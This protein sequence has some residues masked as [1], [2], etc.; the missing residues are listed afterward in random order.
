ML[1]L[2]LIYIEIFINSQNRVNNNGFVSEKEH[3]R[4]IIG[5][6]L[7]RCQSAFLRK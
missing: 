5:K 4:K 3:N 7:T 1:G 6:H 2:L